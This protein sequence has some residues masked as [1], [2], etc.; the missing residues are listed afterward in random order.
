[1]FSEK[2]IKKL[3][4]L[5][6]VKVLE[7]TDSTN[8]F[9]KKYA[10]EKAEGAVVIAKKQSAGRGRLGRTFVSKENGL[11]MSILIKPQNCDKLMLLTSM[12]AVAVYRAVKQLTDDVK[13]KWV[14]DIYVNGKKVAG[15]LTETA[16]NDGKI[17]YAVVGI[18][19]NLVKPQLGMDESI[20]NIAGYLLEQDTGIG[21]SFTADIIN[22]FFE[23]Y[24]GGEFLDD[25][26][27]NSMLTGKTVSYVKQDILH[28][29]V[30]QGIDDECGLIILEN[31]KNITLKC[32]E[33][34]VN[35]FR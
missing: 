20:K 12:A 10:E 18:G 6:D 22:N 23:I 3:T 27:N 24:N 1:M 11:Y 30:V 9:L 31:G 15:I 34:S 19:V 7:E 5:D 14:N 25:Y 13:I 16:F 29:G 17:S 2:E 28:T 8:T 26:R 4:S 21:N 33:V 35:G 32:G